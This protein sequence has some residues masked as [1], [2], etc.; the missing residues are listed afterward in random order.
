[1]L[2]AVRWARRALDGLALLLL[3]FWCLPVARLDAPRSTVLEDREGRLLGATIAADDQWRFPPGEVPE[4]Y[5]VAVLRFEDQRFRSHP[6]VDPLA[7][8]RAIR[9]NLAAGRVVSGGSTLTMQVVR[10]SRANPPRTVSEKLWEMALALRLEAV[11]SKDEILATYAANAPFG[12]NTVGLE[13][14]AWR[15]FGRSPAELSWA[16]AATLAVLPNSPALVHPG[17]NR[18]TLRRKRDRLLDRLVADGAL[19]AED[20]ALAKLEPLPDQPVPVPRLAPHLLAR[21]PTGTRVRS[22][23][24]A[25]TQAQATDAV[26][27]HHR[28]LSADG[29]ENAAALVVDVATGEVR[30]YV[31]NVPALDDAPHENHVDVIRAPRSTGSTLKPLLYQAM[32]EAGELLPDQL[33]PDVPLRIGSFAPENFGRDFDGAVAASEALARSRNVPTAWMLKEHGVERFHAR[34]KR[35]GMTTLFRPASDYGLTLILGG[36]EG[37]LWDLTGIYRDLALAASREPGAARPPVHWVAGSGA[38]VAP[39]QALDPGAAFWTLEAMQA[40]G[41]P[42][43]HASWRQFG[44]GRRVA[45]KTGTSFGF[46]DGWAIGVTPTTAIGVWVGNAD[47]EGRPELTGVQAA[48][49]LLFELFDAAPRAGWFE[50]PADHLVPVEVCAH[51]GMRAGPDCPET[52]WQSVPEA[53]L[54]GRGCAFCQRVHT[55]GRHRVHAECAPVDALQAEPWFVLPSNQEVLYARRHADY[56]PLPDWRPDCAPSEEP[57]AALTVVHPRPGAEVLVPVDL[58]GRRGALALEAAHRDPGADVHWHLDGRYLA[59]THHLH[60]LEVAPEPGAH[61]L[62]L[63]DD[64]GGRVERDFTVLSPR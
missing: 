37:T 38:P 15:Y 5:A 55:D 12:G 4:R 9:L 36:A 2:R 60:Q 27:R 14:A 11:A 29:I 64:R 51:S 30:A 22:T 52:R 33:V 42:G 54:R 21:V 63:V 6:G 34:L 32:L 46:R 25:A 58:D 56:R 57:A 31:G 61:R 41:R 45:W 1:M 20:G 28:R 7:L 3:A 16:E 62:V 47:G 50:R 19:S 49:P 40:V 24:D 59:T 8:A 43:V 44:S 23:L 10:L 53:G 13:A 48:A 26:L 17:R 35:L 18:E 39:A